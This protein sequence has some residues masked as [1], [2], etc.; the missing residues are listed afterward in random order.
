MRQ[1]LLPLFAMLIIVSLSL[2]A[3]GDSTK[4]FC[5]VAQT[6][7]E[8]RNEA[9]IGEYYEHLEATAPSEIKEDVA[10][11]RTGWNRVS[12]SL[13][14]AFSGE[15]S[16]IQ[17]PPEVSESARNILIYVKEECGF[18]GGVYLVFPEEGL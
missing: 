17:R 16:N 15:I 18:D 12:F 4:E 10:I 6:S 1:L 2:V 8:E 14:E 5:N 13:S 11:L 9:E 3:C 7:T